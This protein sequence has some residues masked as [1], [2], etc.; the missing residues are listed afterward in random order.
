MIVDKARVMMRITH[1]VSAAEETANAVELQ[2]TKRDDSEFIFIGQVRRGDEDI[3]GFDWSYS[4]STK[5]LTVA[6]GSVASITENDEISI[7]GSWR[8]V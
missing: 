3:P 2:L 8:K 1:I 4:T 7:Y 5:I 6:D